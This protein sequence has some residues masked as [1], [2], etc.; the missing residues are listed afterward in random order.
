[1][2]I[3]LRK[4]WVLHDLQTGDL[5]A[6]LDSTAI[7]AV[8][9]GLAGALAADVLACPDASRIALIGAGVQ[10]IWQLRC[11]ALVRQLSQALV[12]D[13]VPGK[14]EAFA[15]MMREELSCAVR[16]TSYLIE[17]TKD[18]EIIVAVTWSREPFLFSHMVQ[19]GTHITTLG[20]DEPGKCEVSAELLRQSLFICDDRDLAVNM[21]ALGEPGPGRANGPGRIGRSHCR[22]KSRAQQCGANY[23]L[24][25][26]RSGLPGSCDRL[27]CL[28][29]GKTH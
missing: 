26:C 5:L 21:G 28:S 10:G 15:R 2:S 7:T 8:R 18:A 27:V 3:S 4:S 19:P 1:M 17:A 20:A 16:A 9:T 22:G 12:Y 14:A 23:H 25:R 13:S 6:L 24:W 29:A 11:L